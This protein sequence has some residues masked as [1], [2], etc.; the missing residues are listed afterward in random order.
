MGFTYRSGE[1]RDDIA[2]RGDVVLRLDGGRCRV[3]LPNGHVV[4]AQPESGEPSDSWPR[5]GEQVE[6]RQA[7]DDHG[8]W[9]IARRPSSPHER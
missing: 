7:V 3:R 4:T 6:V 5:A 1:D 2:F 9:R 8:G